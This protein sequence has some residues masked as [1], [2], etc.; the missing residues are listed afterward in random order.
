M[1]KKYLMLIFFI[2][3]AIAYYLQ[4]SY[5]SLILLKEKIDFIKL[6]FEYN[7]TLT[8]LGFSLIYIIITGL[9]IPGASV[10]SLCAGALFGTFTGSIIVLFAATTGASLAFLSARYLFQ[11]AVSQQYKHI[12]DK[13]NDKLNKN[14]INYLLSLRLI[15]L[16]PFFLVNLVLGITKVTLQKFYILSFIGM[17]PGIILYVNAGKQLSS[18]SSINDIFSIQTLTSFC[19][20]GLFILIPIIFKKKKRKI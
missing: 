10:L 4:Q 12:L 11:N 2:V 13:V 19:L 8:I 1:Q 6:Y 7:P 3:I 5:L 17:T 9:S 18:I 14:E 16:F 15:P 20:L